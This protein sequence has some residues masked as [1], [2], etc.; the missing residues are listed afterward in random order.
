MSGDY[1]YDLSQQLRK[2]F[3]LGVES[4]QSQKM[5]STAMV[6]SLEQMVKEN[7]LFDQHRLLP[8]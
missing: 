7:I 2:K 6:A 8:M 5:K 1:H 3:C 4:V